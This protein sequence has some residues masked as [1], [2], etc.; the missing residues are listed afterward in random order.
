MLEVVLAEDL[1]QLG[2]R[3]L[4]AARVGDRLHLLREVDLQ[5]A[6]QLQMVL[7]LHHVGDAALPGLRVDADDRLVRA[8]DVHRVDREVRHVPDLGAAPLLRDHALVDRVLV[9]AGERGVDELAGVGVS[10]MDG[11]LV[12]RLDDRLRLVDLR[13]V[14]TRVDALRS[15]G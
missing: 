5:P 12:A 14:E 10:R 15:A 3:Q 11:Q 1:H 7:G 4:A 2:R 9:G 8:A 6:R 13:E